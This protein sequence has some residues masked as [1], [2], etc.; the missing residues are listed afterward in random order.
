MKKR[1]DAP[2]CLPCPASCS[3]S[4]EAMAK[5][6]FSSVVNPGDLPN[7]IAY[8]KTGVEYTI[9][10]EPAPYAAVANIPLMLE[11]R[12]KVLRRIIVLTHDPVR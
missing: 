9:D 5:S 10:V 6:A 1:H 8:A 3:A 11:D 12:M 2:L 7:D 4:I